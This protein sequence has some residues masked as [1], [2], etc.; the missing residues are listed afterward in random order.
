MLTFTSDMKRKA[1]LAVAGIVLAVSGAGAVVLMSGGDSSEPS[2]AVG[3]VA[4]SS[5]TITSSQVSTTSATSTTAGTAGTA[6][7]SVRD[8]GLPYSEGALPEDPATDPGPDPVFA[9][10]P[11]LRRADGY[12]F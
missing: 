9:G 1:V 4:A 3:G 6:P 11:D 7:K 12:S 2:A 8:G 5:T 10:D